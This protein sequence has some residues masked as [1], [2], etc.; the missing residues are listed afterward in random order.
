I[1]TDS[2]VVV[3]PFADG[4][5][6]DWAEPTFVGGD[7]YVDSLTFARSGV[8]NENVAGGP[9]SSLGAANVGSWWTSDQVN[10]NGATAV[11]DAGGLVLNEPAVPDT[12]IRS[13]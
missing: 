12:S 13:K 7:Y 1:G 8:S 6:I 9:F 2:A 11:I 5:T 4:A 10:S 3:A